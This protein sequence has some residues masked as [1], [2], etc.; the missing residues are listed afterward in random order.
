MTW[1]QSGCLGAAVLCWTLLAAGGLPMLFWGMLE[2]G[3]RD[4]EDT[5][6]CMTERQLAEGRCSRLDTH[7][8]LD[9]CMAAAQ[10]LS[11]WR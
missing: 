2:P 8:A 1:F 6:C 5:W 3:Y 7:E 9:A 4:A 11:A 10:Q